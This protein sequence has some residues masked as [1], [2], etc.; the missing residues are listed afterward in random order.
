MTAEELR[1]R[2]KGQTEEAQALI[3]KGNG[4]ALEEADYDKVVAL[5]KSV[6]ADEVALTRIEHQL[7]LGKRFSDALTKAGNAGMGRSQVPAIADSFGSGLKDALSPL[8]LGDAFVASE[9]FKALIKGGIRSGR[10]NTGPIQIDTK[11][12]V[13][14]P[15]EGI[16]SSVLPPAAPTFLY[17]RVVDLPAQG[18]ADGGV[19]A[20]LVELG[21]TNAAAP[22]AVG[23]QKPEAAWTYDQKYFPLVTIAH[24]LQVPDQLLED[25]SAL[26]T[27]LNAQLAAGVKAKE[28]D[29][30]LNG[31][32][33]A[34][35]MLGFLPMPGKQPDVPNAG[36]PFS[37]TLLTAITGVEAAGQSFVDGIVVNPVTWQLI[38][39]QQ[40][41]AGLPL[42]T[43]VNALD[44]PPSRLWG[45]RVVTT[46]F[47]AAGSALVGGF[48]LYSIIFR[49]HQVT[50]SA[51]NEDRD[52][53]I[54]NLTTI[55]AESRMVLVVTRPAAFGTASGIVAPVVPLAA[56][57][58]PT[59]GR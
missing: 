33:I 20:A 49:G 10:F 6:S 27:Y 14:Y 17:P 50:V 19:V 55:R 48:S 45:K 58:S 31:T 44:A 22:V 38:L 32:G 1:T 7:G 25:V 9:E 29:Q 16:A 52:N 46:P 12:V 4:G 35:N 5:D 11:A 56:G 42:V 47:M 23:A 3:A 21:Y 57:A 40:N 43:G 30:V 37:I 15:A 54:K 51:S 41:A 53:F 59:R 39:T 34:P 36:E 13:A 2:I 24:W 26:R 8:R 18:S 28:D